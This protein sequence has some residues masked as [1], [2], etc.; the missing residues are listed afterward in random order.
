MEHNVDL[1][2]LL[3]ERGIYR[4][5]VSFARAMDARDWNVIANIASD[6]VVV[7]F[8]T[9]VLEGRE[10]LLGILQQ[11]LDNC[12]TT[13]H[14]LG[15]VVIDVD[16]ASG[17]ATSQAYVAD[18]H[19]SLSDKSDLSFRTLGAYHDTWRKGETHWQL[20]K[21]TKNNRATMGSMEV[22]SGT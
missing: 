20:I 9:G 1:Q 10:A 16:P 15:N 19:L 12:G 11:F 21:R 8:G 17:T 3:D 22:F 13:Q 14:M 18:I 5:L 6:D 2:T 7:D 4:Q